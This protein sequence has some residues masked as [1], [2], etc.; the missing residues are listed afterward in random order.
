MKDKIIKFPKTPIN[1]LSNAAKLAMEMEVEKNTI[2]HDIEWKLNRP[3][4]DKIR[5]TDPK[6]LTILAL[7]GE[8]MTFSP[9]TSSRLISKLAEAI[10]QH[11]D[12][13]PL[14]EY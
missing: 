2:Q 3:D 4:W 11:Q 7:F 6:T 13:D 9:V 1:Q 5:I 14:E 8:V 10:K 12:C